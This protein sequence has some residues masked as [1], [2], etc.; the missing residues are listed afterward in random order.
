MRSTKPGGRAANIGYHGENPEP[1]EVPLEPVQMGMAYRQIYGVLCPGGSERLHRI[2]RLMQTGNVEPTLIPTYELG[3][4]EI[5][6][7]SPCCRT[8]KAAP[9]SP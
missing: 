7:H 8:K 5:N 3:L 6:G 4:D 1:L 2:F 9:Q